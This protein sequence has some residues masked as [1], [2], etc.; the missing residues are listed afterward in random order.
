MLNRNFSNLVCG[1]LRTGNISMKDTNGTITTVDVTNS[2]YKLESWFNNFEGKKLN[3][4]R[5]GQT[6]RLSI[7]T[8]NTPAN[9]DDYNIESSVT[10]AD[11]SIISSSRVL[12]G[13]NNKNTVTLTQVWQYNGT[14][15]VDVNEIGLFA[16]S[17]GMTKDFI[18]EHTVLD[19]PISVENGDTFTIALT[20]GGK[21]TVTVNS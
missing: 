11:F 17:Y 3:E 14:G 2:Y 8:G 5:T 4:G 13:T 6:S 19:N 9:I 21:A 16:V 20:I 18:L 7:G 10:L 12:G 15:S 1:V